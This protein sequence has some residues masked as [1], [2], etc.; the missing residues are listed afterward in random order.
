MTTETQQLI[1]DFRHAVNLTPKQLEQWLETEE[2]QSV[3]QKKD[4]NESTGHQAG[5]TIVE[6]LRKKKADYSD[7]DFAHMRK[8]LGYIK[9]HA[10]QRPSQPDSELE[11][12]PW[13]YSLMNWGH[14]PMRG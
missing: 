11:S 13:R 12:T 6:I 5:R 1:H 4:G 10:A 8:V 9:R 2:S 14:D 7:R 3:G